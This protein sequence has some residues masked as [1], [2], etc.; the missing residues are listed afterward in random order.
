MSLGIIGSDTGIVLFAEEL[1]DFVD[2][3]VGDALF[4]G[5]ESFV[6]VFEKVFVFG[7]YPVLD[8]GGVVVLGSVD[9]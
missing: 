5:C 4:F 6:V 2:V 3:A 1:V 7:V 9:A 8:G